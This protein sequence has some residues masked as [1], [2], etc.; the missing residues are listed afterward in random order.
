M[1]NVLLATSSLDGRFTRL[2]QPGRR[3]SGGARGAD[4][5]S[6]TSS[7]PIP[8]MS[9]R[10]SRRRASGSPTRRSV[11]DFENRYA[12]KDGG[13]RWLLWSSYSDGRQVYSVAQD[14]AER[15]RLR[16]RARG[17]ARRG[18]RRWRAPTPSPACPTAAR[19]TRSCAARSRAPPPGGR[20]SRWRCST[21]TA[22]SATTT[23][24]PSGRR[25]AAAR[26]AARGGPSCAASDLLARYG[27]EEFAVLLPGCPLDEA[28]RRGRAARDVMPA[29]Q[30]CSAG[31]ASWDGRE[32][33]RGAD[34]ARGQ[35]ALRGQARR[36]RPHRHGTLS[37][38]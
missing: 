36:S 16:G 7:S 23:R 3:R 22:S 35:R 26:S 25:S 34:R 21:S 29:E 27:G 1:A 24:R 4:V 32:T 28:P 37:G 19:G 33:A 38:R 13:W 11:I 2:N 5:P 31:V 20:R 14:V 12:T 17:A 8:T 6:P 30:T 10:R 15:K 18:S 9:S